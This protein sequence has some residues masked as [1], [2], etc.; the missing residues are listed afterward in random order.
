MMAK[1]M[2]KRGLVGCAMLLLMAVQAWATEYV[3]P[4]GTDVGKWFAQ[5]PKDATAVVFSA[6]DKYHSSGDIV[7]PERQLLVVDGKGCKL[8]LGPNSNGFTYPIGNMKEAM[9][10]TNS[11]Y[12][13]KDFASITGGRKAVDLKATLG[14]IVENCEL[15][16]QTEA[17]ID[18]RFCLLARLSNIRITNPR[19]KGVVLRQGDWPGA[20]GTNSQCNSTVLEQVRVYCM[21]TTTAAFTILNSGGVRMTECVSEGAPSDYDIFLSATL[22]GDES[23]P[24]TNPVVKSFSLSN[25]HVEHGARKASIYVNMPGKAVVNLDNVYWNGEQKAPV[26]LYTLGQLNISNIGWWNRYFWI[27][28]RVSA[29]RISISGVP[30][31]MELGEAKVGIKRAGFLRLV[32]ALPGNDTLKL[33]YVQVRQKSW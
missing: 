8:T 30:S 16:A 12:L 13:I 4:A 7:L 25:F 14:S 29:P 19:D 22:D 20:T 28:S 1:A 5:L 32:D 24:A 17:A 27:G 6:A 9:A 15:V 31:E 18:L 3:V 2:W 23:R 33:N 21:N 11:R 26:V 10:R